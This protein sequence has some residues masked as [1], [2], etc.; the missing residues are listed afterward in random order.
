MLLEIELPL[1]LLTMME[2]KGKLSYEWTNSAWNVIEE[3][4]GA[5]AKKLGHAAY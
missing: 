1:V 4:N 3:F 2:I 5:S